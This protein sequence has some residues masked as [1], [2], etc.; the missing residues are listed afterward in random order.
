[1]KKKG[2]SD[3]ISTIL[4]ITLTIILVGVVWVVVGG[5][6]KEKTSA[7]SSCVNSFDKIKLNEEYTCY[8]GNTN[9]LQVSIDISEVNL[10]GVIFSISDSTKSKSFEIVKEPTNVDGVSAYDSNP[11]TSLPEADGGKTYIVSLSFFGITNPKEVRIAPKINNNQCEVSDSLNE[12]KL[13][14]S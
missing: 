12:L 9:T 4:L 5:I 11:L 10:N 7:S 14:G 3:V 6:L 8:D 13:C 2:L 1:M